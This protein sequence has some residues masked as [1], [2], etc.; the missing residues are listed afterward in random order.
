MAS[1]KLAYLGVVLV[2]L[3]GVGTAV[4]LSMVHSSG[5]ACCALHSA[6]MG[7]LHVEADGMSC[8][9]GDRSGQGAVCGAG[10]SSAAR[11]T[12]QGDPPACTACAESET[13]LVENEGAPGE[14]T[15]TSEL[16][17]VAGSGVIRKVGDLDFGDVVNEHSGTVLVDFYAEWC[18]PCQVQAGV[19]EAYAADH[20]SVSIVKVNVDESP[21]LARLYRID[22]I[23]ALKVFQN[24]EAVN[25]H[26]GLADSETLDALISVTE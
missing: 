10:A 2:G 3:F 20:A 9:G 22:A 24:G 23:P 15:D 14:I 4:R 13:G 25:E 7:A 12:Y 19:L 8:T 5:Q 18:G 6:G 16:P 17:S 26:I 1:T 21:M 11:F